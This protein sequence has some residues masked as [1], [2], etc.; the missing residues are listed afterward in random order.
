MNNPTFFEVQKWSFS[1][2]KGNGGTLE[3]VDYLICGQ[4]GWNKT[5]LLMNYRTRIDDK[6]YQELQEKIELYN[7]DYPLQYLIGYQDF[8]GLRLKVT[9]D[10]L[11]PRPE[12][13][14]LV[15]WIL[16]DNSKN[17]NYD[18]LD[19][20][21]GTGAIGLALKSIRSNWNIFLSDISEPALKVAK[22]NAQ[23][24][25]LDVSFSTSDLFEK[26]EGKKDIIVSN[27]PYISENEKI[28]MDKSVLNY[29]PHQALFAAQDGYH[30]YCRLFD[31]L[32]LHLNTPGWFVAEFGYKQGE[33]L[34]NEVN[35]RFKGS[36]A[37]VYKDYSGNDRILLVKNEKS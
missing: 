6:N 30:L 35:D 17:E 26:I 31:G 2:I 14:E 22:E 11:I 15:D 9:K 25:N 20:G 24:L 28:Y 34:I 1:C 19:V 5:Q 12:T 4:M 27:P 16:N 3:D 10:T 29:E 21:T 36:K 33:H 18:V 37:N 8:Y 13:E 7:Q 23:N 32:S